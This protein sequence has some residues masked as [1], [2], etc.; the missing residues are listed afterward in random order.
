MQLMRN[1]S[2]T[3]S[4]YLWCFFAFI[5]LPLS[6][7]PRF[8]DLAN[9]LIEPHPWRQNQTA[10]TILYFSKGWGSLWDYRSLYDGRLWN[11]VIE[12]P[13]YQWLTAKLMG[14]GFSLEVA[15]RLI[16]L[17][18]FFGGAIYLY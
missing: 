16:C 5:L 15:G 13:I 2:N 9:P 12:F 4:Y 8:Y 11:F 3:A 7:H 10:L 6:F 1:F 18:S 17:L 14:T